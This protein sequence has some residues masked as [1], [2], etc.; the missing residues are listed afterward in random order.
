MVVDAVVG[1]LPVLANLSPSRRTVVMLR[2]WEDVRLIGS[3]VE[4]G[5]VGFVCGDC[6][7]V[8]RSIFRFSGTWCLL[9]WLAS[10]G[11]RR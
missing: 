11:S 6:S 10:R 7:F 2:C 3:E 8:L 4:R 9:S 1:L 5:V